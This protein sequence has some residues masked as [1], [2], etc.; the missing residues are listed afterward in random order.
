[1]R[2]G[3]ATSTVKNHVHNLLGKMGVGR[4]GEAVKLAYQQ[5]IIDRYLPLRNSVPGG[6]GD[7]G[8]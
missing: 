2:L 6:D 4:R 5:G 7:G 3:I 1:M 8:L